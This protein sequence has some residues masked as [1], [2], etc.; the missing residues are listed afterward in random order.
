MRYRAVA[1]VAA[2]SSGH[3]TLRGVSE[4][5]RWAEERGR[6]VIRQ[7]R[8]CGLSMSAFARRRGVPAHRLC[9]WRARRA[10]E[11]TEGGGCAWTGGG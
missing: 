1:S 4:E 8:R 10:G 7:S 3:R 9:Y 6:E 11:P 2:E 5:K